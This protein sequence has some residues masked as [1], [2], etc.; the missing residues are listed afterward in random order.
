MRHHLGRLTRSVLLV[1][2]L[3]QHSPLFARNEIAVIVSPDTTADT[4][5][6]AHLRGIYLRKIFLDDEGRPFIPVNLPPDSPLRRGFSEGLL[7]RSTE[8]LQEYWN[9]RYFQG[10]TPPFVLDSQEAVIQF[11]ARTPGAVGYIASCRLDT[12]VKQVFAFAPPP[13]QRKAVKRMCAKTRD[14]RDSR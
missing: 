6:A 13:G 14:G 4:I 3:L 2:G 7:N 5:T 12:R 9:Q 8:Q 1:L 10:V 11:V